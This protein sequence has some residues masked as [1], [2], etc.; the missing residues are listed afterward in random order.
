MPDSN[1][2]RSEASTRRQFIK[3]GAAGGSVL[4][5][6]CSG[7]GD[8]TD[9]SGGGTEPGDSTESDSGGG[10]SQVKDARFRVFDPLT[11]GAAPTERHLNP[12]NPSQ[13]GCWHPGAAI[14]DRLA[15]YSPTKNEA[16]P[17]MAKS[18]EKTGDRVFEATLSDKWT[19]HNGDPFVAQDYVMEQQIELEIL[20]ASAKEGERPH[21]VMKSIEAVDDHHIRIQLHDPLSEI[22]AVQNTIGSYHGNLGR[23]IFTKHDDPKWKD[24][25]ERLRNTSGEEKTAVIEEITKAKY[26][27]L[28]SDK[29]IGHG[30][31]KL[32]D[33]GDDIVVMEKYEDHPNADNINFS[34]F[35][36]NLFSQDKPTQPYSTGQADAAHKGFPVTKDLRQQ[37]PDQH[38]LFREGRSSNKLF[39]FNCGHG[40]QGYD[41]PFQSVNVRKAVCHVFDRQSVSS[42][43]QGVNRMFDWAPC[44]VPGKVMTEGSHPAAKLVKDKFTKYGT[45]DTERA[46]KLLQEDGYEKDGSGNWLTPDG[47]RFQ[48]NIMNGAD[49]PDIQILKKNLK[50]FGI[51]VKQQQVDDATFDER[52]MNGEY[53]LMPDGSSANGITALWALGL[54]PDWIQS[55]THFAPETD[56]PMPIGDPEGSNGTKTINIADHIRQW[57]ATGENKYHHELLWWWN[58]TLPEA[59]MMYQPDAGAYNAQNWKLDVKAGIKN[60]V[61]DALYVAPKMPD[62]ALRYTGN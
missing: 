7:D 11:S 36:L 18:W 17:L 51:A 10:G 27:K 53:D 15:V 5:A 23:G 29:A 52:R 21:Q 54:V 30:P 19:W 43:L 6:G 39:A 12:W 24:W 46:T 9:T 25:H 41:S 2:W 49:R 26:P 33:V 4:L 31:F 32:K 28:T 61:D 35:S 38:T 45:N 50:D 34:E 20:R 42:L 60:G 3:Y 37:L 59:E 1:N 48:I 16:Y 13:T 55:I 14:M 22:F 56:I 8:S 40:V 44:R 57:Q 47:E 62:G 58:Q